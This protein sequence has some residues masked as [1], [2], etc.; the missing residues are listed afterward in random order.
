[1]STVQASPRVLWPRIYLLGDT[2][3]QF[4]FRLCGWGQLIAESYSR[5]CDV[6]ARGFCGYNTRAWRHTLPLV[7]GPED[8]AHAA[9]VVIM[10]GTSDSAEPRD[11]E[12]SHVPLEEYAD[13]MERMIDYLKACGVTE[14]KVILVTP[15]PIDEQLWLANTK[16]QGK[17]T[18]RA[19]ASVTKYA[20][21]CT[22]VGSRKGV[23]VV[24]AHSDFLKDAHWSRLL[25]DG[26]SLS[27]AG[28]HKLATLLLP[29]IK[30]V[31]GD[32]PRLFP[33]FADLQP[34]QPE[35]GISAWTAEACGCARL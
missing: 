17:D 9:A 19:L 6:V 10:L 4:A 14:D 27:P 34:D 23:R 16:R 1:M 8:A 21:E 25:S 13:N 28:S 26:I 24:D 30:E 22:N 7:L 32:A 15:P 29:V 20:K 33:D 31:V 12:G 18:H 3:T 5:R 35:D 2:L 11:P